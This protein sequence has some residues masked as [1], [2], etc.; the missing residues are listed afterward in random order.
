MERP[1]K[2]QVS[3]TGEIAL[4]LREYRHVFHFANIFAAL[5]AT[6]AVVMCIRMESYDLFEVAVYAGMGV[7]FACT[8]LISVFLDSPRITH[9]SAM[10]VVIAS[11]LFIS[12]LLINNLFG[13]N[14]EQL[15]QG[16]LPLSISWLPVAIIAA[17]IYLPPRYALL[18]SLTANNLVA[19]AALFYAGQHWASAQNPM[20]MAFFLGQFLLVNNIGIS[21]LMLHS[22]V[23][24]KASDIVTDS[25]RTLKEVEQQAHQ[26]RHVDP[27]TGLNNAAG[28]QH[29]LQIAMD[30]AVHEK[31]L[32]GILALKLD[33]QSETHEQLGEI[34]FQALMKNVASL[35]QQMAPPGAGLGRYEGS[36]FMLWMRGQDSAEVK[37]IASGVY[38][39]LQPANAALAMPGGTSWSVGGVSTHGIRDARYLIDQALYELHKARHERHGQKICLADFGFA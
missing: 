5:M 28:I 7:L 35:L 33:H 14:S 22:I 19:I 34:E 23:E 17:F 18:C 13:P 15:V 32:V 38:E 29:A 24:N 31:Q 39:A 25:I 20:G 21:L 9:I 4:H 36:L 3:V 37:K 30:A 27:L 26:M 16:S 8:L 6:I 2:V 12:A 11:L 10:V 1:D